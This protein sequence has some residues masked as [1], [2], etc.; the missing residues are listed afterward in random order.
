[1]NVLTFLKVLNCIVNS[2][3]FRTSL[4]Q[5]IKII[6]SVLVWFFFNLS[7]ILCTF[8]LTKHCFIS[9]PTNAFAKEFLGF[10]IYVS[11]TTE[12]SHGKL[13]FKDTN[14]TLKTIPAVFNTTCLVQGQYV[15]YYN[16]RIEGRRAN[17]S[18]YAYS[19]LCEVEVYGDLKLILC[20]CEHNSSKDIP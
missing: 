9:G 2:W 1:M 3:F 17:F 7:L 5:S 19:D 4:L 20:T 16:Q 15:I 14:F 10:S 18:E 11:N 6:F 12:R 8:L 13:C